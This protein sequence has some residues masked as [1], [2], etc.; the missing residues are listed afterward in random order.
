MLMY[1]WKTLSTM[2]EWYKIAV[3]ELGKLSKLIGW[4]APKKQRN[5][6]QT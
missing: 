2:G 1:G 4:E 6:V 3:A 5:V